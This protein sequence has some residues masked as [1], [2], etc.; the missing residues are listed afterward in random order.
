MQL[1]GPIDKIRCDTIGS[2]GA[3]GT[4][5]SSQKGVDFGDEES[6]GEGDAV[7]G[8]PDEI[9]VSETVDDDPE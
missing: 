2:R 8:E 1:I 7:S 6:A 3:I 5:F 4:Q 9:D